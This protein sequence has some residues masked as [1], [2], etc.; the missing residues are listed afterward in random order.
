VIFLFLSL[1]IL[2]LLRHLIITRLQ[3]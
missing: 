2:T 1:D 3:E